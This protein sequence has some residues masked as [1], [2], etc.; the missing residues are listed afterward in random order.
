MAFTRNPAFNWHKEV[1]GARWFRADLH[2]HTA[3]DLASGRIAMPS[4]TN[5]D[6]SR[7]ESVTNYAKYVLRAA[8]AKGIQVLGLTPHAVLS[9]N[10]P[11]WRIVEVWNSEN[12]DDGIP[13]REKIYAVYPGFEPNLTAGKEG[14][15]LLFLFDPEIGFD[16]YLRAFNAITKVNPWSGKQL[17]LSPVEPQEAAETLARQKVADSQTWDWICLA[18]HIGG[19]KGLLALKSQILQHFPHE[20][21]AGLEL[22]D[23]S[24][25]EDLLGKHGYLADGARKHHHA[26]F[27]ASDACKMDG[28][29]RNTLGY[30]TTCLKLAH[31]TVEAL[32][33]AFLAADSRLRLPFI[34]GTKGEIV[35]DPMAPR[36]VP[37]NRPWV[38]SVKVSGGASFFGGIEPDGRP[39]EAE[40][41]FN[42]DL[43]CIIGSRLTGKSVLL[44]GMRIGLG[45][46]PP[47]E[48]E[49]SQDVV[50]R[51]QKR[52]L[53]GSPNL[54]HDILSSGVA[55]HPVPKRWPALFFTQS[56][57]R[58]VAKDAR[59]FTDVLSRM[60]SHLGAELME[61]RAK[62]SALDTKLD[63][64][65][66]AISTDL[67]LLADNQQSFQT[68]SS[69]REAID[70]MKKVRADRLQTIQA[71]LSRVRHYLEA[72]QKL[73]LR[74]REAHGLFLEH[75]A[76]VLAS[77]ELL[78]STDISRAWADLETTVGSLVN[79]LQKA[80][81]AAGVLEGRANDFL[82][83]VQEVLVAARREVQHEIA[84]N[85]GT[86]EDLEKFDAL[87]KAA[88]DVE[89]RRLALEE[90]G[91]QIGDNKALFEQLLGERNRLITECRG[92]MKVLMDAINGKCKRIRISPYLDAVNDKLS[93]WVKALKMQGISRW[94]NDL[95]EPKIPAHRLY[96]CLVKDELGKLEM[97]AAVAK[98][99][100]ECMT[101]Q[102]S[103]ELRALPSADMYK[104]EA[105]VDEAKALYRPI[106]RLSGGA[107][108]TLM[109]TLLVEADDQRPLVIDQPEDE[110][111]KTFLYETFLPAL[112]RLKGR[113][114]IIFVT[115]DANLV[116]N[117]DADHVI[118]LDAEAEHGWVVNQGVIDNREIRRLILDKLDGGPDAFDLR[119]RKYGF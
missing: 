33:Q 106:E 15:H 75:Q 3:D 49:I 2:V 84:R 76:P 60:D 69:A 23:D 86:P 70:R 85:G 115:H 1:P 78:N 13:F 11:A 67:R 118:C 56:E 32:R 27:Y 58:G 102:R 105:L 62:L 36:A 74:V 108:V 14:I 55:T 39:K 7:P 89:G 98:S 66:K 63:Q 65:A 91:K 25:L 113:R 73:A 29:E 82:S 93:D 117:G 97:S 50:D 30:R 5:I 112:R 100:K 77:P 99:F 9:Q 57:L 24:L 46:E 71:D 79:G 43:T 61:L 95:G 8:I 19:D 34:K 37:N 44:D 54:L 96:D 119:A 47:E 81:E 26:F 59:A 16:A 109:L 31:P 110:T 28:S 103:Y 45:F 114:Q 107:R 48:R 20:M 116:V 90:K 83:K 52:F 17:Q 104:V 40:F 38:R 12:D 22:P 72:R 18:P 88:A 94:W 64:T 68:S 111:D 53:A 35:P 51:A 21:I 87:S 92:K 6:T 101:E 4:G 41:R 10:S 42:P 80:S